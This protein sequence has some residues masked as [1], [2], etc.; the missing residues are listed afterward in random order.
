[1]LHQLDQGK[2]LDPIGTEPVRG[3]EI[4]VPTVQLFRTG[5]QRYRDGDR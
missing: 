3:H 1:M 4:V 2:D 5:V